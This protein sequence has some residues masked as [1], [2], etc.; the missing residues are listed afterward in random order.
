[1]SVTTPLAYEIDLDAERREARQA[2]ILRTIDPG[3]ILAVVDELIADEPDPTQHPA[4]TLATWYLER[5]GTDTGTKPH[6]GML[7][8]A[9]LDALVRR[10]L[11][12]I[13]DARMEDEP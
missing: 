10:A 1:M 5:G 3:D 12:L 2:A 9:R 13:I 8:Q 6:T 4:Y 7:A 11:D